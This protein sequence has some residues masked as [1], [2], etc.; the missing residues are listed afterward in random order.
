MWNEWTY[1]L[2]S[3]P[4]D[5]LLWLILP[6]ILFDGLRYCFTALCVWTFDFGCRVLGCFRKPEV[7]EQVSGY[8]YCPSISLVVAGL[9]EGDSLRGTLD[10]LWG[11][12]PRLQ[13]II[14][15]D[16]STDNMAAVARGFAAEHKEVIVI[17]KRRGG[18]SSAMNA[19]LACA[20]G[21]VTIVLDADS[22]LAPNALWEIVQP[23]QDPTVGAVS[24]NVRV[25]NYGKNLLTRLQAFEYLRSVFLGRI[26]TSRLGILG[27]V[28]GAFG[29]F[30]TSLLRQMGGWDV[31]PGEDEDMVLRI[32][33]LGYKV[34]FVS[35]ADCLTDVPESWKVL[36][37][38]RRRW[39]WA[40]VTF[41]SRKHIDMANPFNKHFRLS[42]FFLFVERWIFNLLLPLWFWVYI[43]WII[44]SNGFGNLVYPTILFYFLYVIGDVIQYLIIL[45]YSNHVR[46]DLS[47]M[48]V[49][50]LMPLYQAYQRL[51]T[52]FAV[53]E[54]MLSRRSFRDGFVPQHVRS[55]TWHW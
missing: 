12:Y 23:L 8:R 51:V 37:K 45:D 43:G 44:G 5:E 2:S 4:R 52:T 1:W 7:S 35:H 17:S 38:Q 30:R 24:G 50:P 53:I 29:A 9:N 47:A 25:R 11:T 46:R 39:E 18:K 40:V 19:G 42:N 34:E 27:I 32:R 21:E 26:V 49:I 15:D 13:L 3:I 55:V 33:K 48:F 54:E 28:S 10:R 6:V 20:T 22:E 16:G 41:E 36:T 31:G 14:V